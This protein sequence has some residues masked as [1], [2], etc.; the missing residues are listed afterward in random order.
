MI[1]ATGGQS[2]AIVGK[3]QGKDWPWMYQLG[4]DKMVA[5]AVPHLHQI[6]GHGQPFSVTAESEG[7]DGTV[8]FE[9]V[10]KFISG[11]TV[12]LD[13][14]LRHAEDQPTSVRAPSDAAHWPIATRY[15]QLTFTFEVPNRTLILLRQRQQVLS[16]RVE[17]HASKLLAVVFQYAHRH[18]DQTTPGSH[19]NAIRSLPLRIAAGQSGGVGK[20]KYRLVWLVPIG[21][22]QPRRGIHIDERYFHVFLGRSGL[23]G[24]IVSFFA[25]RC[26]AQYHQGRSDRDEQYQERHRGTESGHQRFPLAPTPRSAWSAERACVNRLPVEIS[27]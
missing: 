5:L 3:R 18:R 17:L 27:P 15:R 21:S 2:V 12:Y 13:A 26:L 25:E 8:M 10:K 1:G 24:T 20:P 9:S 11:K 4:C 22:H 14:P 23:L 7:L 19:P 6:A 16:F